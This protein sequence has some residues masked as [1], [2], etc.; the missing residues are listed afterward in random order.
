[1]V[2]IGLYLFVRSTATLKSN[3]IV[4]SQIV[5]DFTHRL[6]LIVQYMGK[7]FLPLNLSVFPILQDT[8][9]Y[10][11]ITAVILLAV[12]IYFTKEKKWNY[13]IAGFGIFIVFLL[14]VL[15]VPNALNEQTFEHRLYLP[16]TGILL[17]LSQTSLFKNNLSDRNLTYYFLVV[18][19]LFGVIN[20]AHQKHFKDALSFWDQAYE[21]SPN[22]AYATMM[23]GARVE[24]K[25]AGYALMRKAYTLNPNEKYLNYY[26]GMMLQNQDS[27]LQSEPYFLK[28][29]KNSG[30]Y[31]CD[32][33]LAKVAF[34]KKNFAD[35]ATYLESYIKVDKKNEMANNNLLLLYKNEFKDKPKAQI[36]VKRMQENGIIVSP[37]VQQQVERMP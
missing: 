28:E 29:K 35:A 27:L 33:Y 31:E 5:N 12:I 24:D 14:P 16:L 34:Y 18:I 6:P 11:G 21:T 1:M 32:F 37:E 17:M 3:G 2:G 36:Q 30:Y 9:Y 23:Y 25:R 15:F 4:A 22:S 13:Y 19:G 8:V 10:F 7:I 20:Y 26:Y